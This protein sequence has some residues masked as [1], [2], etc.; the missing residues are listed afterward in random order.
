LRQ[1]ADGGVITRNPL[2]DEL[3]RIERSH[4]TKLARMQL[5]VRAIGSD[6]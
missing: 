2:S 5:L 6:S 4:D 1:I 3:Q